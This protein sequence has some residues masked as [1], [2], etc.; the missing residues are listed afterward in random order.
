MALDFKTIV[1]VFDG[2]LGAF[3]LLDFEVFKVA[4]VAF[5]ELL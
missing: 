3:K 5:F 2:L 4:D 1:D